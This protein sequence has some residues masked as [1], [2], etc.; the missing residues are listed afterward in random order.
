[1]KPTKFPEANATHKISEKETVHY[2]RINEKTK[3]NYTR[4]STTVAWLP[5]AKERKDIANG[6]PVF[7]TQFGEPAA[8]DVG[9]ADGQVKKIQDQAK[10]AKTQAAKAKRL[11]RAA[12]AKGIKA[13]AASKKPAKKSL[14]GRKGK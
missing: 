9:T 8:I 6:L 10:R 4:T 13:M 3:D 14:I 1:M 5:T 7:V 2:L 12:T 11:E